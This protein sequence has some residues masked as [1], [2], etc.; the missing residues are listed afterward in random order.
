MEFSMLSKVLHTPI[1]S[2]HID[3][4]Q[5]RKDYNNFEDWAT[6]STPHFSHEYGYMGKGQLDIYD[7]FGKQ[8]CIETSNSWLHSYTRAFPI[9]M[10]IHKNSDEMKHAMTFGATFEEG[11][12]SEKDFGWPLFTGDDAV[13]KCWNYLKS[14]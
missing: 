3:V 9:D 8:L 14:L 12:Y 1:R 2:E 13:Q 6:F 4:P 7:A 5:V 11:Y 10:N